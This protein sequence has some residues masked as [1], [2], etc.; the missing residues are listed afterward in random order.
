MNTAQKEMNHYGT[1][2]NFAYRINAPFFNK[3][4]AE[5]STLDVT[6]FVCAIH[7]HL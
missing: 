2:C 7:L 5:F 6:V 4:W 1:L 3:T